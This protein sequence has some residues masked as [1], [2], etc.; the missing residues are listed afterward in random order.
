MMLTEM[1][2]T[3]NYQN[4]DFMRAV[5]L[6]NI[7]YNLRYNNEFLQP[8]VKTVLYGMETIRVR[9]LQ[10]WKRLPSHIKAPLP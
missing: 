3:K 7:S 5:S 10:L 9:G 2:K 4:P 1:F 6:R 8:Q